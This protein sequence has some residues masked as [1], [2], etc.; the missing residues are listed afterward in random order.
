MC[1]PDI[2]PA[3]RDERDE[4]LASLTRRSALG[5]LGGLAL[6][7]LALPLGAAA[8]HAAP[9]KP[10]TP[11]AP[12]PLSPPPGTFAPEG[13]AGLDIEVIPSAYQSMNPA[14]PDDYA[15]YSLAERGPADIDAII[16]H[17]TETDY[18]LAIE[19][20][21]NPA[22]YASIHYVIREDGRVTQMVRNQ[23]IAWHAGNWTFN[24]SSIGI[25]LI[26]VAEEPEHYTDAQYE[27]AGRLVA[28]LCERY[29]VPLDRDH[30]LGHENLPGASPASHGKMHWD[31]G[32]YYDWEKLFAAA[33]APAAPLRSG[34]SGKAETVRIAP[35]YE[36]NVRDFLS[37][38]PGE[39]RLPA[40]PT[41]VLMV[42]TA[43]RDDAPL[44]TDPALA[45]AKPAITGQDYICDW[46]NQVS[47]GQTFAVADRVD[48]WC[49]IW[50]SGRIG[51][52]KETDPSGASAIEVP[53]PSVKTVRPK[54][55][56][57][58]KVYGASFPGEQ[59]F[60]AAGLEPVVLAPLPYSLTDEQAYVLQ[61]VSQGAYFWSPRFDG[62]HGQWVRDDT[63]WAR[64]QLNQRSAFVKTSDLRGV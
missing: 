31:P 36:S 20:F 53:P 44:L 48:G 18:D 16:I 64:I 42:R 2:T 55:N 24:Q 51:W 27:S 3:R 11:S 14:D 15:S 57:A 43:P 60:R 5:G 8:A 34:R 52:V 41:S 49:G 28:Y 19:I 22:Y 33:D 38:D 21:T 63:S 17:D 45:A 32:A 4:L 7:G 46:G 47:W 29:E 54:K 62:T 58:V 50:I 40:R 39:G 35:A 30:I 6:A 61:D 10:R 56:R 25:E 13:P 23:D 9:A 26:G 59:A 37:C 12:A 1:L